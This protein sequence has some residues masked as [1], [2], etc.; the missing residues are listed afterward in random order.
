MQIPLS[1]ALEPM[2]API[3]YAGGCS[4]ATN[5]RNAEVLRRQFLKCRGHVAGVAPKAEAYAWR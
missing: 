4:R 1:L 3:V 2:L 5:L